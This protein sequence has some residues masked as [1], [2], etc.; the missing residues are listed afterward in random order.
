MIH[1]LTF[2]DVERLYA[3][4]GGL[5]YGE[6]VTQIEHAV[7]CAALARADGAVPSLVVAAF[8]HDIGHL[9]VS[10]ADMAASGQDDRHEI[11]GAQML[12]DMFGPAVYEPIA[13]HVS[14]KRYLC[15]KDAAYFDALSR[16]SKRSLDLQGG[17]FD[18]AGATAFEELP[19]WRDAV[20]LR[21]FDDTG[22]REESA[23]LTFADFAMAMRSLLLDSASAKGTDSGWKEGYIVAP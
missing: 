1:V 4:R 21:R 18:A 9:L 12:A 10:E 14:A 8:L 3:A 13:L 15:F 7:Q 2:D 16:A 17:P 20:A 23:H 11:A 6:G 22:K 19:H 5:T